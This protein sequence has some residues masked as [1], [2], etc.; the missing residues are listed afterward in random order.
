MAVAA[1]LEKEALAPPA[2]LTQMMGEELF[3]M[4]DI[5]RSELVRGELIRMPP[6]GHPHGYIEFNIGGVLYAFVRQH[7]LGRVLGG[8]V[9]I[10]TQRDPDTVRAADAAFI[11]NARLAQVRSKSYLDVAPELVVEVLS[12]E[13]AWSTVMEKLEEYFAIGVRLIWVADPRR[14]RLHV[15]RSLTDVESVGVGDELPGGD[16]LPGFRAPVAELFGVES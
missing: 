14:Q 8:E 5:G 9:G 6:A 2:S 1:V 12:P 3:A 16:V 10:Y 11:S 13:D 4:G 7:K 15:Y